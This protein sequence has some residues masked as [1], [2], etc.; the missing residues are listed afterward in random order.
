MRNGRLPL[1]HHREV[2]VECLHD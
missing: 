1:D 2:L